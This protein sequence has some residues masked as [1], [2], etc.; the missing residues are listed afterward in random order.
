MQVMQALTPVLCCC[1]PQVAI[2]IFGLTGLAFGA[3]GMIK[4]NKELIS[5]FWKVEQGLVTYTL[6]VADGVDRVINSTSNITIG[7]DALRDVV[8]VDVNTSGIKADV[9]VR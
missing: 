4:V 6:S 9:K 1:A 5:G 3:F 7:L 2:A 8:L